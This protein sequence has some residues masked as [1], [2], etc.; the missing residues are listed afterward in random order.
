MTI[1]KSTFDVVDEM[2]AVPPDQQ[3]V[4]AERALMAW[5]RYLMLLATQ[6]EEERGS[7]SRSRWW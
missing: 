2:A 6:E 1:P 3:A 4:V 7:E 5:A